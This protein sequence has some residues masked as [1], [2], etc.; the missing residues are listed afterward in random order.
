MHEHIY[1]GIV[2]C[3]FLISLI[4]TKPAMG[5]KDYFLLIAAL[6]FTVISD[7]CIVEI[8][9]YEL[10]VTTFCVVQLIYF[11][12]HTQKSK[13]LMYCPLVFIPA[14]LAFLFW[15]QSYLIFISVVYA[16]C[17]LL[18]VVSAI[19]VFIKKRFIFPNSYFILFGIILFLL[20]DINVALFNLNITDGRIIW[21]FYA[22][23]Q[24][25]LAFSAHSFAKG[26]VKV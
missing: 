9:R 23:S 14:T 4:N 10:G 1:F 22:P 24:V 25:L 8:E 15:Q 26:D 2:V 18:S 19:I 3:C 6:F 17:L 12:R 11:V 7:L 16:Q 5:K 13:Y 21:F 20:C